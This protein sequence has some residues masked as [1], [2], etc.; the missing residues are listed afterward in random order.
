MLHNG[1]K[2]EKGWI[3]EAMVQALEYSAHQNF[4]RGMLHKE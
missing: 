3:F 2:Y 4:E 1:G